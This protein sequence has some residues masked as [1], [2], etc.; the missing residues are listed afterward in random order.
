MNISTK[1]K[2]HS[3]AYITMCFNDAVPSLLL[4]GHNLGFHV[5]TL[6]FLRQSCERER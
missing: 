4:Q 6:V 1:T 5:F 2:Y 3:N